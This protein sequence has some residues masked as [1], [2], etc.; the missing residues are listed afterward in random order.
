MTVCVLHCSIYREYEAYSETD[1]G[2]YSWWSLTVLFK[3]TLTCGCLLLWST[4]FMSIQLKDSFPT[5]ITTICPFYISCIHT[6]TAPT[7]PHTNRIGPVLG[8][9]KIMHDLTRHCL[10]DQV[11]P[12]RRHLFGINII[13]ELHPMSWRT[14]RLK[15]VI[16]SKCC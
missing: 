8:H 9:N 6:C 10:V 13:N 16:L 2:L 3:G 15:S 4:C 14:Q 12:L 11:L 7:H 1:Q 5:H